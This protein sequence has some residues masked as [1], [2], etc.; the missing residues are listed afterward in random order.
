M[1]RDEKAHIRAQVAESLIWVVWQ[2]LVKVGDNVRLPATEV[3]IKNK[4]IENMIRENHVHQ[5]NGA[6]ETWNDDG[7]IPMKRCLKH[8]KE[9]G[10]I[11]QEIFD[12]YMNRYG[13]SENSN[14]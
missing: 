12:K 5:I 4:A 7:M 3:M 13:L 9:S 6:I 11:N 10:K 8:M 1:F 14:D 2:D